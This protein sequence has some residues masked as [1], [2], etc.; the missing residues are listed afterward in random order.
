MGAEVYFNAICGK[1]A[2]YLCMD[3]GIMYDSLPAGDSRGPWW[4][5]HM[6]RRQ[7]DFSSFA[8]RCELSDLALAKPNG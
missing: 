4:R 5:H 6:Q 8:V 2:S 7:A 1:A 3:A